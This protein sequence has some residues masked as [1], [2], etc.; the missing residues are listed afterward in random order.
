M[1]EIDE[2][3]YTTIFSALKHGVRRK[4]LRMLSRDNLSF[5]ALYETLEITSSHLNYQ[6]EALGELISK[7]YGSYK[8]S[9]F[10]RAA[11]NMLSNIEDP[12]SPQIWAGGMNQSKITTG[13][14]LISLLVISVLYVNQFNVVKSQ[15]EQLNVIEGELNALMGLP[16]LHNVI[17]KSRSIHFLSQHHLHYS[18]QRDIENLPRS[19]FPKASWDTFNPVMVFYAPYD[20]LVLRLDVTNIYLPDGLS[21]PL[22]LQRGNAVNNESSVLTYKVEFEGDVFREWQS[23]TLWTTECSGWKNT[24]MVEVPEQGWYTLSLTGPIAI[25]ESGDASI[26]YMWGEREQWLNVISVYSNIECE[27]LRGSENVYF[28]VETNLNYGLSGWVIDST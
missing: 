13:F 12:P 27:L 26:Q 3:V 14:L 23:P 25:S 24:F 11:V 6:L 19:T 16:T 21:L 1:T 7:N 22:T 4:I 20:D 5:T 9:M 10:G 2:E 18:Y 28:A 15:Q 17:D 8:L